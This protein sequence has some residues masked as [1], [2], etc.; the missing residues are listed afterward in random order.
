MGSMSTTDPTEDQFA[1][2]RRMYDYFNRALFAGELCPVI[3][4]FSRKAKSLGFFAPQ[5]WVKGKSIAHEISLNPSYFV[6]QGAR[7][8]A[9]TLVHEMAHCW[10]LQYGDFGKRGYHNHEWANKMEAIGLMPSSTAA[11]GGK[12]VGYKMSH[13][14]VEGGAFALAYDAMPADCQLPWLCWEGEAGGG[15]KVKPPTSKLKY[16]CPGCEANAWAK[17]GL[18]LRCGDCDRTMLAQGDD[19]AGNAEAVEPM[20][21]A[22]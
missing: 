9:S 18:C 22:A 11:P 7:E 21:S 19:G 3:L 5:R 17:P 6:E 16:T 20:R 12:R 4:N 15:K 8:V 10:Q 1:A 2:Y 13:Y 14:I